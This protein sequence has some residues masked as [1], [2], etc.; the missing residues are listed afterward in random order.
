MEPRGGLAP[1]AAPGC[2]RR[3]GP[4]TPRHWI[5]G[6]DSNPSTLRFKGACTAD[7]ASP[8]WRRP[9]GKV[10]MVQLTPSSSRRVVALLEPHR[11]IAPRLSPY[12]GVSAAYRRG[13]S[14]RCR[15]NRRC[16]CVLLTPAGRR[17]IV[18]GLRGYRAPLICTACKAG[19]Q[20]SA[21]ARVPSVTD[22]NGRAL[23]R[24]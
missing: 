12:Q 23:A 10:G 4:A 14:S 17:V 13:A 5:G 6:R 18:R 1:H 9:K 8:E 7:R 20:S 19:K 3:C 21:R 22:K 11:G 24:Y 15:P 2:N 16:T